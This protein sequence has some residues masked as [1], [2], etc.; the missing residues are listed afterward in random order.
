LHSGRER[1]PTAG[2]SGGPAPITKSEAEQREFTSDRQLKPGRSHSWESALSM[3]LQGVCTF[4]L[5]YRGEIMMAA[6]QLR[7][8]T[9]SKP[10][11]CQI[12]NIDGDPI[13]VEVRPL[14]YGSEKSVLR[15]LRYIEKHYKP[16]VFGVPLTIVLEIAQAVGF[17]ETNSPE[18]GGYSGF[19]DKQPFIM[20]NSGALKSKNKQ[21]R[22]ELIITIVHE[23]LHFVFKEDDKSAKSES[24]ARHDL[25]CYI[26][27]NLGVP[28]NHWGWDRLGIDVRQ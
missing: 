20:L 10:V 23:L 17:V 16:E 12:T 18:V 24:E 6:I 1:N 5:T 26:A 9:M 11:K 2:S 13:F 19:N 14:S 3:F 7:K 4:Q 22:K 8:V 27:L 28:V 21:N 15:A 25:Q